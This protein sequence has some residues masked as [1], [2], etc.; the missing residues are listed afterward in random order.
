MLLLNVAK[1]GFSRS[2]F[3]NNPTFLL[4]DDIL[5][6]LHTSESQNQAEF[7]PVL[8]SEYYV[9]LSVMALPFFLLL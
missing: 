4:H 6:I 8:G 2:S 3:F 7:Q 9:K 5:T 1:L